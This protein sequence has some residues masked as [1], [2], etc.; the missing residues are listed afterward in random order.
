MDTGAVR[1]NSDTKHL[2]EALQNWQN[3]NADSRTWDQLSPAEQSGIV[4]DAQDL[5]KK[6]NF[7]TGLSPEGQ[8]NRDECERIL[9]R[10]AGVR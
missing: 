8:R 2:H 4:R 7:P 6:Q 10:N 5:K 1:P 9:R 3:R